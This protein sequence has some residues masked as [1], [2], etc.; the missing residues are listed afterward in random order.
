ME[1][2][3]KVYSM[4]KVII[5]DSGFG[6]EMFADYVENEIAVIDVIRVIDWRNA[7]SYLESPTAARNAALIALRPYIGRVDV[8]VIANNLLAETSLDFFR[9]KFKNQIFIGFSSNYLMK[10]NSKS[11][12]LILA[13]KQMSRHLISYKLRKN[14]REIDL[15]DWVQKIDDGELTLEDIRH[16]L[17]EFT[18][19][20]PSH[21]ILCCTQFSDV[22]PMLYKIFGQ[23]IIIENGYKYVFR[24][25]CQELG[26]RGID[27]KKS[28]KV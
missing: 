18:E 12:N 20:T 6:G 5:F 19:F 9:R 27:G 24:E 8:I 16:D 11:D 25:L 4:K 7:S 3:R 17:R 13:T 28:S 1:E 10:F 2:K 15:D 26:F 14:F 23:H 21:I 22:K